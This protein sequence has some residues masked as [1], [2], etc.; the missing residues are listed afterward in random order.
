[1]GSVEKRKVKLHDATKSL[2]NLAKGTFEDSEQVQ[3]HQQLERM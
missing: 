2:K 1:M 3:K